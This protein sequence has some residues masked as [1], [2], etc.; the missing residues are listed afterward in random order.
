MSMVET[1]GGG[2]GGSRKIPQHQRR[3]FPFFLGKR[4][5]R[6]SHIPTAPATAAINKENTNKRGH[7]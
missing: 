5:E 4:K 3:G 2:N 7:F 6:V 1:P